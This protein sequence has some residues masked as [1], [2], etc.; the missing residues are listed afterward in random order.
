LCRKNQNILC[1]L[2]T[3]GKLLSKRKTAKEVASLKFNI[4]TFIPTGLIL[5]TINIV[6]D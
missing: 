3:L 1:F 2:R 5:D 6:E 4:T